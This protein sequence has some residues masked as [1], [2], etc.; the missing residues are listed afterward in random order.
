MSELNFNSLFGENTERWLDPLPKHQKTLILKLMEQNEDYYSVAEAY[1]N[2]NT[3]NTAS[4]SAGQG[5]KIFV[6]KLVLEIEHFLCGDKKYEEE[7]LGLFS[8][9]K[10]THTIVVSTVSAA[11]APYIGASAIFIMPAVSL[12]FIG[13]GKMT[14]NAWCE[15]R[16][17]LKLH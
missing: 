11:V 10:P 1:L 17:E 13:I 16:K 3:S 15:M 2:I 8:N 7:R 4:F 9:L 6:D 5:R 14:I 12:I